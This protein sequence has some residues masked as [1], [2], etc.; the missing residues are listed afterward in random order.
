MLRSLGT[1]AA[2]LAAAAALAAPASA[3]TL[4]DGRGWEMVSPIEK[5]GGEIP[6]PGAIFGG[7]VFQ[8]A[9]DGNS[10]TYS[11]QASFA[12]PQAAS[13]AGQYISRRAAAGWAT[14]N[15]TIPAAAGA[16][17]DAPDGVPYQL[18]SEGLDR[19]LIAAPRRCAG[20]PCPRGYDLRTSAGGGLLPS[21]EEP[22]LRFAG[23]DPGLG[24]VV[25]STCAALTPDATQAPAAPA[26]CDPT[27]TNLYAWSG[28]GLRL[29][30]ILPG[31][32]VG[33][34][35]ATLASQGR[36]VSAD[37]SRIYFEEAGDL[38]LREAGRTVQV[39]AAP[40][41]G[42][43]ASFQ[44]ASADGAV[45]FFTKAE[46][47]YRYAAIGATT[48]D[49][50]P[51]G[52]VLGVLGASADGSYLYYLTAT[53]LVLAH[54][55]Q[56]SAVA[57][58]AD[59]TNYPPATGTARVAAGGTLAF[60][61]SAPLKAGFDNAGRPEVY[62][63]SP[64]TATL[65]CASCNPRG[66]RPIGGAGI[67]GAR[68]N[69]SGPTATDVYKPRALSAAGDRLFFDSADALVS[70]DTN[71]RN[72]VYEWDAYGVGGC[73]RLVGCV[74]LISSG[75]SAE[76]A[77][78][79][80]ASADGSD[81]FFTTDGSLVPSDPGADDLYDARVGGGFPVAEAPLACIGD[82]CQA[83]PV[84]P[85]DPTPGTARYGTEGN[86]PVKIAK[87]KKH[88]AKKHHKRKRR[89][90]KRKRR[91]VHGKH[92]HGQKRAGRGHR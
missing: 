51:G 43:G 36:A 19:G 54:A 25:L 90:H 27:Q 40:A 22:D 55:G 62:V 78:F 60:V 17:G 87:A 52:G 13:S 56:V 85:E 10:V 92:P 67:P 89:H 53:G 84:M 33:T 63:Y 26:A 68:A 57:A 83:V 11:S 73:P 18:F 15:V 65:A 61:A 1:A 48:T 88:H 2:V 34:P 50:T 29:V 49:L 7:G 12:D 77:T 81:V 91:R 42:G 82:A 21:V 8:A 5:N 45:A 6:P 64:A 74:A 32:V 14:E 72:D 37:G 70:E 3:L 46:H 24:Q 20:A 35:G 66:L 59:A 9:A 58:A 16:F 23:A 71:S 44:T 76:G 39:D 38:Y 80:D 47:L 30:N 41:V 28:G 75:R 79:V 69:G 86:P 4:P 31:D